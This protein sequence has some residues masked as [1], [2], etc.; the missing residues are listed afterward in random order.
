MANPAFMAAG[1]S[2]AH[3]K[4]LETPKAISGTETCGEARKG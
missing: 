4:S 3:R 1:G 2:S